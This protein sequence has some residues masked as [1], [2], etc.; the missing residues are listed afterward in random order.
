MRHLVSVALALV[1]AP[2]IYISAGFSAIRFDGANEL[3]RVQVEPAVLG[4]LAAL[5][6]GGLYALLLMA[7]LSPVG[8]FLAGLSY[9]GV[10]LWQLFDQKDFLLSVPRD[11]FGVPGLL[12]VPAGFGTAVLAVPL[13]V[14]VGSPRRW[15]GPAEPPPV[16]DE[17]APG[18]EP[19]AGYEPYQP[20]LYTPQ[21]TPP[22]G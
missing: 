2:L 4:L 8:P 9:L 10:T 22:S 13:L 7:R 21:P 3:G 11:V 14:T 15:R 1:V 5:L 12:Q 17:P 20:S 16:T 18:Y 6:A 19:A